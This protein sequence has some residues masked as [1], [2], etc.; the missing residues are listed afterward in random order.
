M[1]VVENFGQFKSILPAKIESQPDKLMKKGQDQASKV[2][3]EFG[4]EN[5]IQEIERSL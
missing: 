4:Q 1:A 3:A 5:E 2:F